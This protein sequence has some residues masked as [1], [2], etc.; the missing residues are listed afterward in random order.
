V[1][2]R[3]T[4]W[5]DGRFLPL[6]EARVSPLDRGFLFADAAYEV[7]PAY[8][9]KPYRLAQHLD[10]LERSL[11]ELRIMSPLSR[12][13]WHRVCGGLV[14]RNGGGH[15]LLYLQ[16]SR[17]V[18]PERRHVPSGTPTPTVFGMASDLAPLPADPAVRTTAGI[19]AADIRWG[20][21]DIKSTA[22]LANVLLKWQAEERGA[23]EALLLR[24]GHLT[25]GSS[26]SVHVVLGGSLLTPPPSHE[27]L[28]GT[29][30]D[31]LVEL[32]RRCGLASE[33][34]RVTEGELRGAEEIILGSAGGGL[35]A[36]TSLDGRTVGDGRPGPVFSALYR[37]WIA[38]L[39]EF[40][41][42]CRE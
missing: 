21:C 20:R 5:L 16:V 30:R 19:T 32:A 26:S 24:D 36:V 37:A 11:R 38:S 27:L 39:A 33:E 18:E 42:E 41:T 35:R 14:A 29:T 31:V 28:P 15:L 3:E 9:G 17:G 1:S 40:C 22:L 25:E 23:S 8:D 6:S 2:V 4:A 34:R 7:V 10:R 12:T 13:D